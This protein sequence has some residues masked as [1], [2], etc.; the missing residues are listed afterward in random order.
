MIPET[1]LVKRPRRVLRSLIKWLA[2]TC[3]LAMGV[4]VVLAG[5]QAGTGRDIFPIVLP[6]ALVAS[7][8]FTGVVVLTILQWV[9]RRQPI[10]QGGNIARFIRA[11]AIVTAGAL[12]VFAICVVLRIGF[13][14]QVWNWVLGLAV[15]VG[16]VAFS[17]LVIAA[18]VYVVIRRG[19]RVLSTR[20]DSSAR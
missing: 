10:V 20:A 3:G 5:V 9:Y 7:F 13:G 16:T 12:V 1:Q 14:I 4:I 8:S 2:I 11:C 6:V 19:W 17:L 18:A 15:I